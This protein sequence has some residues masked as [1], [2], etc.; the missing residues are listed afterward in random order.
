MDE[1]GVEQF[2]SISELKSENFISDDPLEPGQVYTFSPGQE[3]ENPGLFRIEKNEGSGSGIKFLNSSVPTLFKESVHFAEQNIYFRTKQLVCNKV[4]RHRKFSIQLR[5]FDS[6]K[7][8]AQVGMAVLFSTLL[9]DLE[10]KFL[11]R[12]CNSGSNQSCRLH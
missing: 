6:A 4:L 3:N 5:A 9:F 1:T 8:G 10:E 2:V 12:S 7:S 11:Q